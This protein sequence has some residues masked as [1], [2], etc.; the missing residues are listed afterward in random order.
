MARNE[1]KVSQKEYASR[2]ADIL[3]SSKKKSTLPAS[4]KPANQAPQAQMRR[5]DK[6]P[7]RRLRRGFGGD[8]M[9]SEEEEE[10]YHSPERR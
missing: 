5:P 6:N 9:G 4:E 10:A 2:A 7:N 1:K 3:S 8:D